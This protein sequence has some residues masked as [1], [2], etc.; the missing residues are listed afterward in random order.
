MEEPTFES[1]RIKELKNERI[2]LQKK[3]F[4]KWI[5]T[6]LQD[7]AKVN[8][9]F[10]DLTDGRVLICLLESISEEKV[11][12]IARGKQRIHKLENVSKALTFLQKSIKLES[13]GPEDVVDGKQDLIL[14]LIWMII[15]RFQISKVENESGSKDAR[16]AKDALLLWCQRKTK[17]YPGVDIRNFTT[18][19]KNG[20][21]FN[22]LIHKHRPDLLD[23][24]ELQ[25][26]QHRNNL[27]QAFTVAEE[28][29]GVTKLLDPED[30]DC[31]RP[32][33]KSVM[34]YVSML[35]QYFAKMKNEETGG[36]RVAKILDVM[37]DIDRMKQKYQDLVRTLLEWITVKIKWL[38]D[39]VPRQSALLQKSMNEF[40]ALRTAEKPKKYIE[41]ANIEEMFFIIQ[42]KSNAYRLKPYRPPE[43]VALSD[44]NVAWQ[45]LEKGEHLREI[46][47]RKELARQERLSQ[48]AERFKKKAALRDSWLDEMLNVVKTEETSKS[49]QARD[50]NVSLKRHE[51]IETD[52]KA[53]GI[54]VKS[55]KAICDEL[56]AE[57]YEGYQEIFARQKQ[58]EEKWQLL[59][60]RM[61]K[62]KLFLVTLSE[63]NPIISDIEKVSTHLKEVETNLSNEETKRDL[64]GID[65]QIQK[66]ALQESQLTSYKSQIQA[67]IASSNE[68]RKRGHP[69]SQLIH[70]K[71][72]DVTNLLEVVATRSNSKRKALQESRSFHLFKEAVKKEC[73]FIQDKSQLAASR[74]VGKDFVSFIRL[75]KKLQVLFSL[76]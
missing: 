3:T 34:T 46:R 13:I 8:D 65:D 42:T 20:L 28:Q 58:I 35:Y 76:Y 68:L 45:E 15:L 39:D 53:R 73:V 33:E 64:S 30:F 29:L 51:A 9:L 6:F 44:I 32:D 55:V 27:N 59:L 70:D 12:R 17:G 52:V 21:A 11:G 25:P 74:E 1:E 36:K 37:M 41:R 40:K 14:G 23:F 24:S 60:E 63:V 57:E 56:G 49:L 26:S 71:V 61:E 47:L 4:T 48:L 22:A 38:D 31:P 43:G 5:N 62:R 67:I 50:A 10:Q 7:N 19:W 16:S 75:Q 18:S 69:Q 54:K 72:Q 2:S 66:H